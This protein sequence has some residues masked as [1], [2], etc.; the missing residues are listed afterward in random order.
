MNKKF[1]HTF[2]EINKIQDRGENYDLLNYRKE[3]EKIV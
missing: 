1:C 2:G 3:N